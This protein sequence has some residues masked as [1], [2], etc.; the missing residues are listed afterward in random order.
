LV[1]QNR[2]KAPLGLWIVRVKKPSLI[3]PPHGRDEIVAVVVRESVA[4]KS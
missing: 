1:V 2:A 4:D 3:E